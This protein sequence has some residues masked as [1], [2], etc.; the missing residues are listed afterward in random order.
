[1]VYREGKMT[2]ERLI[3]I[4]EELSKD[5]YVYKKAKKGDSVDGRWK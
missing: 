2:L 1:M 5:S 4:A 3:S